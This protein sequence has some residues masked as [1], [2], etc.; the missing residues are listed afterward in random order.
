MTPRRAA[1]ELAALAGMSIVFL[2]FAP[3][4]MRLYVPLALV[5]LVYVLWD[6]RVRGHEEWPAPRQPAS[7]RMKSAGALL[8]WLTIPAA[9]ALYAWGAMHGRS[10]DLSRSLAGV[11][12][13]L[14]WA[15]VQQTLFQRYLLGRIR[16]ALPQAPPGA[17]AL[18]NGLAY[19]LVHL[20]DPATTALAALAGCIWSAAYLRFRVLLP[21][22]ASHAVL[23]IAYYDFA[24]GR[25][26]VSEWA[27][28]LLRPLAA[29]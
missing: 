9:L 22:A 7:A 4:D 25:S 29:P 8:A 2:V 24:L 1:I 6:A 26:L 16:A 14:P 20:P 18:C 21:L 27:D 12:V 5:F 3:R 10:A 23:G 11:A 13:Y 17:L 28:R 19:G 15:Y